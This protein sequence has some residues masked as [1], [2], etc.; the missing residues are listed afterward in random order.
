M[1]GVKKV[2]MKER[3]DIVLGTRRYKIK[4]GHVKKR[5]FFIA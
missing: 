2:L 1:I 3:P 5:S 4:V